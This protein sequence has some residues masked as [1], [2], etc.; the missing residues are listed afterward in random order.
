M[1]TMLEFI[2]K[3]VLQALAVLR[4][5]ERT[6]FI[7]EELPLAVQ[8]MRSAEG[9]NAW[10]PRRWLFLCLL[11]ELRFQRQWRRRL[12]LGYMGL[13]RRYDGLRSVVEVDTSI[14]CEW[15]VVWVA[16]A[17]RQAGCQ[18]WR[19]SVEKRIRRRRRSRLVTFRM[20]SVPPVGEGRVRRALACWHGQGRH[21]S[22]EQFYQ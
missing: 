5:P 21:G 11:D 13:K 17:V 1:S 22:T 19:T 10:S 4:H 2:W 3:E 12:R 18:R 9:E 14:G 8:A 7:R 15:R 16:E 20:L 6:V